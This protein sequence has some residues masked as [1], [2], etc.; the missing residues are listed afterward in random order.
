MKLNQ[1]D[2][3]VMNK[4][5]VERGALAGSTTQT[6]ISD[7]E[8]S[9]GTFSKRFE[10][11]DIVLGKKYANYN[12]IGPSGLP[13]KG[14]QVKGGDVI[15]AKTKSNTKRIRGSHHQQKRTMIIRRDIS[16]VCKD[17][18][19]GVVSHSSITTLPTGRRACV[20]IETPR[21]VQVGDKI[22]TRFGQK[23]VVS[24]LIPQE[25]MPYCVRTGCCPDIVASPLSMTSRQ[26][27]GAILEALTGKAVA[28]TGNFNVGLDEQHFSSSCKDHVK[29]IVRILHAHGF[30]GD[31]KE[32]YMDGRTGKI[33]QGFVFTGIVSY[34]RLIQLAA[35]K[36]HVRSTG[37]SDILTR[38]V[39]CFFFFFVCNSSH[40]FLA[41]RWPKVWWRITTW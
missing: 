22:T 15:I 23:G 1:E 18:E 12:T 21:P 19:G 17:L 26:T 33:I 3:L 2:G 36:A 9:N 16:T 37:P 30:K 10:R 24:A 27:V 14:C 25:D 13:K 39:G 31:G 5:A 32:T 11:L 38:Q 7:V 6:Y 4:S 28:L 34:A 40:I 20:S 35:K 8:T 41:S 29:K